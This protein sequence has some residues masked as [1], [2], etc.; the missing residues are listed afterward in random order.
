[1]FRRARSAWHGVVDGL[2][3][4]RREWM[5]SARPILVEPLEPRLLLA[6]QGWD[7]VL[8]DR[9]LPHS[10]LLVRA[11]LSG[12][13]V[14]TYD[15]RR[16][17]A[18]AVLGRVVSLSD[19][20]GWRI[21]SLSILAHGR[22][23]QFML[24]NQW[25]SS[26]TLSEDAGGWEKLAS[27]LA[28]HGTIR[29]YGCNVA[30]GFSGTAILSRLANLTGAEVFA[31]TNIT[32]RGGDWTLESASAGAAGDL[33]LANA[34]P[35]NT[36][37]LVSYPGQL[38]GS[39]SATTAN[40]STNLTG[41]GTLDWMHWGNGTES[42]ATGGSFISGYSLIGAAGV[43][44]YYD[45]PR[46]LSWSDG[47][48]DATFAETPGSGTGIYVSGL[49]NGFSITVPA[50]TTQRM[51]TIFVGGVNSSGQLTAHLS[52]RSA[53]DLVD[54][55]TLFP[56]QYDRTYT[57]AYNAAS[58][59]QTLTVTWTVASPGSGEVALSAAAVGLAPTITAAPA[60]TPS[61]VT[62]TSAA[63][64][65][66]ASDADGDSLTYAWSAVSKPSGAAD[67]TYSTNGGTAS[68][69]TTATF[70]KAGDYTLQVTVTD[71]GGL[72]T[73]STVN[74]IV[75]QTFTS[76]A[77]AGSL[78]ALADNTSYPITATALDQFGD[79]MQAQP[80]FT[81][82]VDG[83][84]AGGT[85]D[86]S[87]GL[88][89]APAAGTG[90]DTVRASRGGI[91]ATG[92][93]TVTPAGIFTA[94]QDIGGPSYPGSFSYD[95]STGTYSMFGGGDGIWSNW[96]RSYFASTPISGDATL[97]AQ[98]AYLGNTNYWADGG[99]MIRTDENADSPLVL[100]CAHPGNGVEM[101]WR[102]TSGGWID[103]NGTVL[104]DGGPP[105]W[106]KLTRSG[107]SFSGYYSTDGAN[108]ILIG[109][110]NVSM[111]ANP[112]AGLVDTASDDSQLDPATFK[113]VSIVDP[114]RVAIPAASASNN[115]TGPT[116]NLSVLGA[117]D[118]GESNLIYGWS[119]VA[120][121]DGA[122]DPTFSV[123]NTNAAKNSAVTFGASGMYT[124]R[125][126]ITDGQ[127]STYS[128]VNVTV[129][130]I[131][132]AMVM[133]APS[134]TVLPTQ[135]SVQLPLKLYDQFNQPVAVL[136]QLNW[137]GTGANNSVSAS[138]AFIAGTTPGV[139]NL[140]VTL[141]GYGFT[142]SVS[143]TVQPALQGWWAFDEN[144]GTSASDSSGM[145]NTGTLVNGPTWVAG[146]S[147]SALS[148][149]PNQA[150]YVSVPDAPGLNPSDS[151][152]LGAWI[153]ATDW[154]GNRRIV[155]KGY[156]DDQ[157]RLLAEGGVLK[158]NVAN[159]GTV[160]APLP[161]TGVWHQVIGT[162]NG[163]LLSI[164]VDG[165]LVGSIAASGPMSVT[166][167]P[168]VIGAKNTDAR[169]ASDCFSGSIDD[170]RVYDHGMSAAEVAALF[171]PTGAPPAIVNPAAASP[172][173]V[174]GDT[175]GVS[176]LA[177]SPD[178]E[179][180]LVYSWLATSLPA[181]APQP[182]FSP[183]STNSAKNA[184]VT[185]YKAGTYTLTC[186]VVDAEGNFTFSSVQVT[187]QQVFSGLAISSG[188]WTIPAGTPYQLNAVE[189]DQFGDPMAV[190][191][192]AAWA[193]QPGGSGGTLD[194][195]GLYTPPA[196]GGTDTISATWGSYTAT[197]TLHSIATADVNYGTGF[198]T[199]GLTLN[200]GAA[201]SGRALVLT[202]DSFSEARSAFAT[203]PVGVRNFT[204]SFAFQISDP[205]A[206]GFTFCLQGNSPFALGGN[207][208]SLGYAGI[209]HSIAIKFD[210]WNNS[211]E[212]SNS[213]GLY[214]DG[215]NPMRPAI[216]LTPSGIDLH[217]GHAFNVAM[218]YDGTSLVVQITDVQTGVSATQT[219]A[220][221]IPAVLGGDVGYAG[222]T[223]G[224]G[225]LYATQRLLHWEY[226]DELVS[227]PPTISSAP[228]S[229]S[230][231]L[232]TAGVSVLGSDVGGESTLT[233]TWFVIARPS[234]AADP[235]FS[236]NGTNSAKN[237]T[238]T[239]TSAG[240]YTLLLVVSDGASS[241]V[242]TLDVTCT[243]VLTSLAISP[244][245]QVLL[246]GQPYAFV[247]VGMDQ[248]GATMTS[249]SGVIWSIDAGGTGA[250]IDSTGTLSSP[251][252][253]LGFVVVNAQVGSLE[254][255]ATMRLSSLG[256]FTSAADI[257]SPGLAGSFSF[258]PLA[259]AYTVSGGG[260][261][262]WN[263]SDQFYF[264]STP[265]RADAALIA[266]VASIGNTD[267]W[268]K[269]GVMIRAST[270]ADAMF[271]DMVVTPTQ[272]SFQ[273]RGST[274]GSSDAIS[275]QGLGLPQWIKLVRNG[276]QFSGWYSAD[277]VSWTL[278]G[279]ATVPLPAS[280]LAGLAVTAHN[281]GL[282]T[283][284]V[285]RNVSIG[286]PP[287]ITVPATAASSLITGNGTSLWALAGDQVGE[288]GLVYSWS[289]VSK[290]IGAADP[291]FSINDSH[292]ASSS[293]VKLSHA[294]VYVFQ[295][296][297]S[298]PLGLTA[299]SLVSV[300]AVQTL[301]GIELFPA[302][303]S[304]PS[305]STQQF[306]A[307]GLD[308][309]GIPM[310]AQP[311][312][313]WTADAGSAGMIG[314]GGTFTAIGK[315]PATI[316]AWSGGLS[317]GITFNVYIVNSQLPGQGS[318]EPGAHASRPG[319]GPLVSAASIPI[320]GSI[321][322]LDG[323]P[324]ELQ[325]S[326]LVVAR[327]DA[328]RPADAE[329]LSGD[330]VQARL[331]Q[332][333]D[334]SPFGTRS[335]RDAWRSALQRDLIDYTRLKADVTASRLG[336]DA[337]RDAMLDATRAQ[338][339]AELA[340]Y[341]AVS[342]SPL[343]RH[344]IDAMLQQGSA[345]QQAANIVTRFAATTTVAFSAGYLLW[346]IQGGTLFMSML[347]AVP[348][349]TWFDPLPVL[350]SWDR[351]RGGLSARG[352]SGPGSGDDDVDMNWLM[353]EPAT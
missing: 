254:A 175:G 70:H 246:A 75:Q 109:T 158:F 342:S 298:N 301:S 3:S 76:I 68:N 297:V 150:Q 189:T 242:A 86:P 335:S 256:I 141:P 61:P 328:P 305:G 117:S 211:G 94:G 255:S 59:G 258:D 263:N 33:P 111:P 162:Y 228:T 37:V 295:V 12:A 83:G 65:V 200:G 164:Y 209:G 219:Y 271:V 62:G 155:Q 269:A 230:Q 299:T 63:L 130:A 115:F 44:P 313:S 24:G 201:V 280:T 7:V 316:R 21:D 326:R 114:V 19:Q 264:A 291:I 55:T 137:S 147:G 213:T 98:V 93:V 318:S 106:V 107:D 294:G 119:V 108:W 153:N 27:V 278:C 145:S 51:L 220:V 222:F 321:A 123:N 207:G 349:W 208:G 233:Y 339:A 231:G 46:A 334:R 58:A 122:P 45:D 167:D 69:D 239:F 325:A 212:G 270:D 214:L 352:G 172:T 284:A 41:A 282:L 184:A 104:D 6:G 229:P 261:D 10:D 100:V 84:G 32:G 144:A 113:N 80:T 251:A 237:A 210:L 336:H 165:A 136:P 315:G 138:G 310:V 290:P 173:S 25:V 204:T 353:G 203:A 249:P 23:G 286:L 57:I 81:W 218:T 340:I 329:D 243:A 224:T 343:L 193:L 287:T 8:I 146:E 331:A 96:D 67:P 245:L 273:W 74:L 112:L 60:A 300:R 285:F 330:P 198:T 238:L 88:Y 351:V 267:D 42:K 50:D 176:V 13:R 215:V 85:I 105:K 225:G 275:A 71:A 337:L 140:T 247:A 125:A 132:T 221:D 121:P 296:T 73:T 2:D 40:A 92:A 253:A 56:G 306:T 39:L 268:A 134:V 30:D 168:L 314:P 206:D 186:T 183:N 182:T 223:G 309:F 217:S 289:L 196:A 156:N 272:V 135:G 128:D 159:V 91:S 320:D 16:D 116:T 307:A 89:T 250:S 257:G 163:L 277:G 235:L 152:T 169:Y 157:Y 312:F 260:S 139:F 17:S 22:P 338:I 252:G 181:G 49:G 241:T 131:Y 344:A 192:G 283:S 327:S 199:S 346:C 226:A 341:N 350:D 319:D 197:A 259:G 205:G 194:A 1:M 101:D 120:K 4:L 332:A 124:L 311:R 26:D 82:S 178:G 47:S 43:T 9:T 148:F 234:G 265:V 78:P 160:T 179:S 248:F 129:S 29:L 276:D 11:V 20:S 118:G 52:D 304:V 95:P 324:T 288:D 180:T 127:Y 322:G 142:Q 103:W 64:S 240:D 185:F 232:K 5:D 110:I 171:S 166:G 161:T 292:E 274:G 36:R 177:D 143:V 18:D 303:F 126:L 35:F 281:D 262:I 266:R 34:A 48:P 151:I 87:S 293:I 308:Q 170:V 347:T 227:N 191:S 202:D 102:T 97:I 279:S 15:G 79:P 72:S 195:N 28:P 77:V 187:V 31:S 154:N 323:T 133:T 317:A 54:T 216:D 302:V 53:A 99:V 188:N 345:G 66:Q 90:V 149:D 244:S 348:F 190:Q 38:A 14:I 236:D 333:L 174:A